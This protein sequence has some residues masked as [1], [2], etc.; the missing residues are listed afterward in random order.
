MT[1]RLAPKV[2]GFVDVTPGGVGE[3]TKWVNSERIIV[4]R[5]GEGLN[6]IIIVSRR[7]ELQKCGGTSRKA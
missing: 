4:V 7:E 2:R 1:D 5:F 3:F 6:G